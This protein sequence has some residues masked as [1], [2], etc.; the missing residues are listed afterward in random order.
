MP[1]AALVAPPRATHI[2]AEYWAASTPP[3]DAGVILV[4]DWYG[5]LPHVR[6]AADALSTAGFVAC[7]T[8]LYGGEHDPDGNLVNFYTPR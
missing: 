5:Q 2:V 8:D 4:H 6:A 3:S 7:A 1:D